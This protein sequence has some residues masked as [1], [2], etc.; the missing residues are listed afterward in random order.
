MTARVRKKTNSPPA[1]ALEIVRTSDL[2]RAEPRAAATVRR[3]VAAAAKA[4]GRAPRN[5]ALTLALADD[6]T[7][8]ALNR[9]WRGRDAPTNVLSFPAA[10]AAA[11]DTPAFLG[12]I[13][14][15]YE[16]VAREAAEQGKPLVDHLAHLAVH[17]FLHLVGFDHATDAEAEVM[18]G[19]E[20]QILL[21]LGMPDPWARAE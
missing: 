11:P 13:V 19:L 1:V 6:S 10:A 18:E 20:S 21:S 15:A 14:L 2:W 3:A 8:Q 7:V 16:T 12:D 4:C 17:G 9:E 5:A